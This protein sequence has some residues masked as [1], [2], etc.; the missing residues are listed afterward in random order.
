MEE[1]KNK[2]KCGWK[3]MKCKWK[4]GIVKWY[5]PHMVNFYVVVIATAIYYMTCYEILQLQVFTPFETLIVLS[6]MFILIIITFSMWNN[7]MIRQTV[8]ELKTEIKW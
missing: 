3:E 6:S 1:T 4:E 2:T 5:Q 7:C 8:E